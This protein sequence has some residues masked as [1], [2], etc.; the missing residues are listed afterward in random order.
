VMELCCALHN[1]RVRL[2]P[3]AA[4]DLIGINSIVP[5]SSTIE[6]PSCV[7]R[8]CEGQLREPRTLG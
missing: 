2:T 6:A 1:F 3:L 4:N 8:R 5:T 7:E